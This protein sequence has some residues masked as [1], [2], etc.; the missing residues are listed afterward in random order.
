[1]GHPRLVGVAHGPQP[2]LPAPS[3]ELPVHNPVLQQGGILQDDGA[4][5]QALVD[6]GFSPLSEPQIQEFCH[7]LLVFSDRFPTRQHLIGELHHG[8]E[9]PLPLQ[10]ANL[11]GKRL[12]RL[13]LECNLPLVILQVFQGGAPRRDLLPISGKPLLQ[14][15]RSLYL[16][17]AEGH[18]RQVGRYLLRLHREGGIRLKLRRQGRQG[19]PFSKELFVCLIK[20]L[21]EILHIHPQE[22]FIP[23]AKQILF[24]LPGQ[25]SLPQT[26]LG[27]LKLPVHRIRASQKCRN[28][29]HGRHAAGAGAER[30][31]VL[32][33]HRKSH[34]HPLRIVPPVLRQRLQG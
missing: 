14:A 34:L 8:R 20:L 4:H 22:I 26:G 33:G 1:M 10:L 13:Q 6:P 2:A 19:S 11:G 16:L 12:Q 15:L 24:F 28:L 3:L 25:R 30:L 31:P 5:L 21:P 17:L 18:L 9:R 7:V 29:L 32:P 27:I 23:Q